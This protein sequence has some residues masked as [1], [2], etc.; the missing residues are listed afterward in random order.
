MFVLGRCLLSS[1]SL[2]AEEIAAL[3]AEQVSPQITEP[4]QKWINY[5][6]HH[7]SDGDILNRARIYFCRVDRQ[8]HVVRCSHL[9][10]TSADHMGTIKDPV[11]LDAFWQGLRRNEGPM[12]ADWPFLSRRG[13]ERHFLQPNH[14]TRAPVVIQELVMP[15]GNPEDLSSWRLRYSPTN[16]LPFDASLLRVDPESA[17][18]LY[19][20]E[21][22]PGTT[23]TREQVWCSFKNEVACQLV[24]A[25]EARDLE[26][27]P[28]DPIEDDRSQTQTSV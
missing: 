28:E 7:K 24:E 11:F 18:L 17:C 15:E 9:Q 19:P 26:I 27:C 25:L 6:S 3:T 8:G 14:P 23:I 10:R 13:Y 12:F 20:F 2:Y 4:F 21:T 5:N 22:R 1:Q 16:S